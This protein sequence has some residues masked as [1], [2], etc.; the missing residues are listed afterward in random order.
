MKKKNIVF[1]IFWLLYLPFIISFIWVN[2]PN[3]VEILGYCVMSTV[4][5]VELF[6]GIRDI[7]RAKKADIDD[8]TQE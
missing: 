5:L 6:F 3:W 2:Y 4:L 1:F 8:K 7:R